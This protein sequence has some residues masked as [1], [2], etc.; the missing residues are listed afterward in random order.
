MTQNY[1]KIKKSEYKIGDIVEYRWDFKRIKYIIVDFNISIKKTSRRVRFSNEYMI[2]PY[3]SECYK[4][5]CDEYSMQ[6]KCKVRGAFERDLMFW[7]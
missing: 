2:K 1:Y 6:E 3:D 5:D 4:Y 7:E